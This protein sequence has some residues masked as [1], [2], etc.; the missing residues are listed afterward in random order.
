MSRDLR[1]FY[2]KMNI[3]QL[4]ELLRKFLNDLKWPILGKFLK[5]YHL[6]VVL[7]AIRYGKKRNK[8]VNHYTSQVFSIHKILISFL[9]EPK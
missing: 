9:R 2:K 8:Y 5:V 3:A 6:H 7:I 1:H 4:L